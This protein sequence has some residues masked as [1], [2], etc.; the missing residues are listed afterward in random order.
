MLKEGMSRRQF[1]GGT[2]AA[3]AVAA[4]PAVVKPAAASATP[5]T[6]VPLPV[7]NGVAWEDLDPVLAARTALEIYRGKYTAGGGASTGQGG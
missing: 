2:A 6:K 1:I 7:A 5:E 4:V 3:A